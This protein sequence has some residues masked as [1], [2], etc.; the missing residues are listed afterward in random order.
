MEETQSSH[1]RILYTCPSPLGASVPTAQCSVCTSS[2]RLRIGWHQEGGAANLPIGRWAHL[3]PGLQREAVWRWG[4]KTCPLSRRFHKRC[5]RLGNCCTALCSENTC[6]HTHPCHWGW[7]QAKTWDC[8]SGHK[9]S[10]IS[11]CIQINRHLPAVY[12]NVSHLV[13]GVSGSACC[14]SQTDEIS[15]KIT[16]WPQ[17]ADPKVQMISEFNVVFKPQPAPLTSPSSVYIYFCGCWN[18]WQCVPGCITVICP[19][20]SLMPA[21]VQR[22][23]LLSFFWALYLKTEMETG[24]RAREGQNKR[25]NHVPDSACCVCHCAHL[26]G[27][28]IH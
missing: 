11:A 8:A 22:K 28:V 27:E 17:F 2:A 21:V 12:R 18:S 16:A 23:S 20:V 24:Q 7:T 3:S 13:L 26:F 4:R 19:V 9:Y 5:D 6:T 14:D 25:N 10:L 15:L 1:Q